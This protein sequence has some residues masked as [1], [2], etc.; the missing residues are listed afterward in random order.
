MDIN[1]VTWTDYR[2]WLGAETLA[3]PNLPAPALADLATDSRTISAGAWFIPLSGESFDGHRYVAAALARGAAGFFYA[4]NRAGEFSAAERACGLAVPDPLVALQ[5]AASGW[6]LQMPRLKLIALTGSAGKTT[7]KDMLANILCKSGPTLATAANFNNEIGVAKTLQ[8]LVPQQRY[9]VL[10]FGA[11]RPGNIEFLCALAQPDVVGLLNVGQAHVG[12]FGS[13]EKLL[14]TKLEIFRNSRAEAVQIACQDDPRI[15]AGARG[16]GKRTLT[17]GLT[18]GADVHIAACDWLPNAAGMRVT[19][20]ALGQTI[21]FEMSVAHVM[22]ALNAAAA[23]AMAL[24]AGADASCIASGLN[25][26]S[27]T[28]GRYQIHRLDHLT[29]IDDTYNANPESMAAGL[30]TLDRSF[31]GLRMGVV[32]GN[33]LELG[34]NSE[35]EHHRIGLELLAPMRPAFIA[36]VGVEAK[37][38]AE[39]AL[40]GGYPAHLL[41]SFDTVDELLAAKLAFENRCDVV[42]IKGSNGVKLSKLVK[43]LTTAVASST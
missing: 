40:A 31:H 25:G 9:A 37:G 26:F 28:V 38:F 11:R 10:E 35:D 41:T 22:F 24:A 27:G 12:I 8:Q 32:I 36:T 2:R 13:I 7:T 19:L 15:L 17:F 42:Y 16:T 5:Q 23:A 6:R 1:T 18:P 20:Q 3:P 33:M 39:G 30:N 14:A 21:V 29:V 34:A 4:A 43:V